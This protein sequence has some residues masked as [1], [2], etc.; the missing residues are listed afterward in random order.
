MGASGHGSW[1]QA[2]DPEL[3][4]RSCPRDPDICFI[5][6]SDS[7][8]YY[9]ARDIA[10]SVAVFSRINGIFDVCI[11]K[12]DY[13]PYTTTCGDTYLQNITLSGTKSY[14]TGNAMIG[15]DITDKV[16]QGSVVINSGSTTVKTSKGANI[17][18]DFEIKSGA[19][20]TITN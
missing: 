5:N 20:F 9:I 3:G 10:D 11:T 7:T 17:T 13:I 19:R 15:S 1:G 4:Q 16:I 8:E 6:K 12:P 2:L 14:E 18:K